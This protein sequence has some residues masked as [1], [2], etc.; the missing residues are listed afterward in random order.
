M[1]IK[2][3]KHIPGNN[4]GRPGEMVLVVHSSGMYLYVKGDNAWGSLRLSG[5]G[6][7]AQEGRNQRRILQENVRKIIVH[8][9]STA[10]EHGDGTIAG[11]GGGSGG[12]PKLP[13]APR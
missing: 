7:S 13:D 9:S 11:G 5:K 6:V 8:G 4:H 1:N 2:V 12:V 3:Q 10:T